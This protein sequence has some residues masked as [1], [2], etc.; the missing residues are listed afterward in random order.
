MLKIS[1]SN[2]LI[3]L[4]QNYYDVI[5][6]GAGAA[7]LLCGAE[8]G[9]RGKNVLILE[10][11]EKP[12]KKILISGGGRCNFTNLFVSPENYISD[13]PHFCKSALSRYTQYDFISLI[14]G[15]SI[16]Y[17]EK[18]LGQ[19]FCRG[20]SVE[21]LNMLLSECRKGSVN[22]RTNK[23]IR[24]IEFD[25]NFIIRCDDEIFKSQRLVIASGGKSIPKMGASSIGLQIAKQFG[26]KIVKP[27]PGL[28][29]LT[30]EGEIKDLCCRLAGVSVYSRVS[31]R[32]VSFDESIL[33]THRG[34]SGPA[35]LQ[36]SN[37]LTQGEKFRINL[38]PNLDLVKELSGL[39]DAGESMET[40]TFF[41]AKLPRRLVQ[42]ILR[43][44]KP[45]KRLTSGEITM[46]SSVFSEWEFRMYGTEGF[47]KA[48][49]MLGG[50]D[51]KEISSKS[52]ES[53]IRPGLFFIGEVL[54]VTGWLGGYNFQWAWSSGY[55]CAQYL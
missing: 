31:T 7:G 16:E 49:V 51:T 43:I 46:L 44:H 36:I 22:I 18:T 29:P 21:I 48:E 39:R 11:A 28:V 35:V 20:K 15:Y 26:H 4:S 40:G 9:K 53:L 37:Y 17:H 34:L 52:F 33:F 24:G 12:G 2:W 13:N 10:H 23:S 6:I 14:S 5:I 3:I 42:E 32:K 45:I 38:L 47:E 54:D 19:L 25:E 1:F 27:G 30:F 55:C 8:A 41:A 50:V